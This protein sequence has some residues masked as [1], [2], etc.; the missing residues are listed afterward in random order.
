[1]NR[2][3]LIAYSFYYGG[4]YDKI[5]QAVKKDVPIKGRK[6]E[7]VVTILDRDYPKCFF[8]LKYPPFVLY[9]EGDLSLLK[10]GHLGIVGSRKACPYALKATAGLCAHYEDKIIVSGLAAGIDAC[11]HAHASKTVGILGCGIERIYPY[12][13]KGL[14]EKVKKEGLVLSEYPGHAPPLG[15]HFPF[16]NRLIAA[17]SEKVYIMQSKAASGTMTT[18]N[19]ALELGREVHVLPYDVFDQDGHNN[20]QLIYEGAIPVLHQ[21]IA[22]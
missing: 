10:G 2:E 4:E 11:A 8:D 3:Q 18:L 6:A 12:S 20:N 1:M 19:E 7:N 5:Y 15:H 14:I 16:R 22:F 9:Y 21:E 13:N 17:L